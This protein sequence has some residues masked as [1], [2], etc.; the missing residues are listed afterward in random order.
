MSAWI[1]LRGLTRE[2]RHWGRFPA[3]L[4]DAVE[5]ARIVALDLPGN[6]ALCSQIS[7]A[8][9]EEIADACRAQVREMRLEP[10]FFLLGLSLGAMVA[11]AWAAGF[12]AEACGCVLI[13]T[14]MRPFAPL[15]WRLRPANYAAIVRLLL[16]DDPVASERLVLR[17]TS[18]MHA[19]AEA[20]LQE[21][22]ALRRE[23]RVSRANALRQLTA[24]AR[25]RAPAQR[26]SAPVLVL[27]SARDALVDVRCSRALAR[28][29]Q[30]DF[31]EHPVAGH[32]LPLDD[33]AWVVEQ[34][35]N[36]SRT[37]YASGTIIESGTGWRK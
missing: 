7:P 37:Q 27:A 11:T 9:V 16:F 32:D 29:W 26:P 10:P 35:A 25:F 20:I 2:S 21:W 13:N 34:V 5:P 19:A 17:M 1:L 8:T 4:G 12:P 30:S 36:W 31:A 22:I 18:R 6:G 23:T 33:A 3:L 28:A 15:H 24:A 14:S